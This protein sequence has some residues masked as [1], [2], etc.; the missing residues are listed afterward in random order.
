MALVAEFCYAECYAQCHY[1]ECRGAIK[2][3]VLSCFSK[4]EPYLYGRLG[5][6]S[7]IDM[8]YKGKRNGFYVECKL[9][10]FF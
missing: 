9:K 8:L 10:Y 1:S 6:P 5:Q 4:P 2:T 7:L 3:N